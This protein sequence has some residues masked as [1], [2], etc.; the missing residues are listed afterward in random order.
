M[1]FRNYRYIFLLSFV[2]FTATSCK[3]VLEEQPRTFFAPS[4]FTTAD[5]LQ[6]GVAGIYSS[7]RGLWGTQ[8]FT[9][10]FNTGTDESKRGSAA[11]VIWWFTYN[12]ASIK[13]NTDDYLGFWNTLYIDINTANGILQYGADA[14]VPPAT[15]TELLAQA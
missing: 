4:F 1:K 2:I 3:K 10:L 6:G 12:N 15:K 11:D 8:I 9:Q 7:F 5:G 13:S 14:N